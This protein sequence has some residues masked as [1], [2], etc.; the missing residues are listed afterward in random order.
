MSDMVPLPA[1]LPQVVPHDPKDN[2]IV[3]TAVAGRADILCTLGRH[4][5]HPD[6][7][8]FCAMHGVRV[9]RDTELL[10]ELRGC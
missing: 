7:T 3:I 6:V 2:P 10:R 4:F 9:L 5:F 8:S 1:T